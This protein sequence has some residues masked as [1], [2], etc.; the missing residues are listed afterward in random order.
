[1]LFADCSCDSSIEVLL[2]FKEETPILKPGKNGW[3]TDNLSRLLV[4]LCRLLDVYI[5]SNLILWALLFGIVQIFLCLTSKTI[6]Y[7]AFVALFQYCLGFG[8]VDI[9]R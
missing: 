5:E 8:S 3:Y 1:M 4:L 7:L 2:F 6:A 9:F